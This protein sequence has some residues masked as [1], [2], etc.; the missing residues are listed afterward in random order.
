MSYKEVIYDTTDGP[1]TKPL[2]EAPME[3]LVALADSGDEEAVEIIYKRMGS[4]E[5]IRKSVMKRVEEDL[6]NQNS[7]EEKVE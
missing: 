5:E 1:I 4:P 3:A 2:D 7:P 6:K